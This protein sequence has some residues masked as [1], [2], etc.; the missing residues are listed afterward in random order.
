[1]LIIQ[2]DPVKQVNLRLKRALR[3]CLFPCHFCS[4]G[5]L[6][7]MQEFDKCGSLEFESLRFYI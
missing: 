7:N 6:D 2:S 3:S 5:V 1:M 4:S